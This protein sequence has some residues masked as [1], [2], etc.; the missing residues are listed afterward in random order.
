[1]IGALNTG[2]DLDGFLAGFWLVWAAFGAVLP[3]WVGLRVVR[4]LL[5][6]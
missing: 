3:V 2:V 1:L 5:D 4:R 6:P